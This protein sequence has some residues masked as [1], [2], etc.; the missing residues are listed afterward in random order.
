MN[1]PEEIINVGYRTLA[2]KHHPDKNPTR[3]AQAERDMQDLNAWKD[4]L[5]KEIR[6]I[7]AEVERR[8][9]EP[10]PGPVVYRQPPQTPADLFDSIS[11]AFYEAEKFMRTATRRPRRR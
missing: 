5:L 1:W 8:I 6:R 10:K 11:D 7:S 9:A 3:R 4:F 2:V